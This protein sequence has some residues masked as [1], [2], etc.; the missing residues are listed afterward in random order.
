MLFR[1]ALAA[2]FREQPCREQGQSFV[3]PAVLELP[4]A[5]LGV[6][7]CLALATVLETELCQPQIVPWRIEVSGTKRDPLLDIAFA[8]G[9]EIEHAFEPRTVVGEFRVLR[10]W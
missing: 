7:Q 2:G 8:F 4:K 3:G 10:A 1:I 9:E 6:S 5:F